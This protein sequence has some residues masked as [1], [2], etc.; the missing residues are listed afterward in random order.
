[1]EYELVYKR[2]K[3]CNSFKLKIISLKKMQS[4]SIFGLHFFKIQKERLFGAE[5]KWKT[6]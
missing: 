3:R 5:K 6:Q 4:G 2:R 1:M